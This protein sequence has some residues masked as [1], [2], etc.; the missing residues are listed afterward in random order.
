LEQVILKQQFYEPVRLP[1]F[2]PT[3]HV[4]GDLAELE[5]QAEEDEKID[6]YIEL[7]RKRKNDE[8]IHRQLFEKNKK[9][10]LRGNLAK[11]NDDPISKMLRDQK[12]VN[13]SKL[14][15]FYG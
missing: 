7:N 14:P 11:K 1:E 13:I 15:Q 6:R 8:L 2:E 9:N 10:K 5:K 12:Q 3:V 4:K